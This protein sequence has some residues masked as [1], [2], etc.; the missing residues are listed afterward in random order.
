MDGL[1]LLIHTTQADASCKLWV[2]VSTVLSLRC[3]PHRC[4]PRRSRAHMYARSEIG[5]A[6]LMLAFAR[7]QSDRH[8]W[9]TVRTHATKS[10]HVCWE[11]C[12][13]KYANVCLHIMLNTKQAHDFRDWVLLCS[14]LRSLS[15]LKVLGNHSLPAF[16]HGILQATARSCTAYRGWCPHK[17]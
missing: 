17:N 7:L 9:N 4:D 6:S 13:H 8:Y 5:Y 3:T 15:G 2:H 11:Y 14:R 10:V 1:A 12:V 16:A